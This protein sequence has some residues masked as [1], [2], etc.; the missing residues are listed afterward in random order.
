MV[1][2]GRNLALPLPRRLVNDMLHFA[3]R[4]PTVPVE[5]VIDVGRVQHLRKRVPQRVG[6]CALFLRAYGLVAARFP[7]L[8]RAYLDFPK[9]RLYEHPYS[10]ASLAF[11]RCYRGENA[12]FFGQIRGPENQ[13]LLALEEHL[14]NYKESPVEQ[15]S[16][17]RRALRVSRFPGPVRRLLWWYALNLS[18][19]GRAR[20]LGTFGLSTYSALGAHSLHPLSPLSTTLNYG[21][22]HEDGAVAVRIVYDHRAMDGCTVAR[23]LAALEEVFNGALLQEMSRLCAGDVPREKGKIPFPGSVPRKA[24]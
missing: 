11:E 19:P 15:V 3:R 14:R 8:R 24:S 20:R 17:Y 7:E 9:P 23:A 18:G 16:L 4:V 12:V 10:I 22:V 21:P 1:Q 2:R 13:P 5:R 6:W